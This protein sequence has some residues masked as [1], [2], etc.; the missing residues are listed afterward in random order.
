M[1]VSTVRRLFPLYV[2]VFV[3]FLGYSLMIATFT[4][5][6]LRNEDG[7]LS[8]GSSLTQRSLV[9]GLLLALYP[10]GQFLGS[11]V[12]GALSDGHGR[13]PVLIASLV[14]TTFLYAGI[15]TALAIQS[16]PL[17][18]LA[19]F[20]A[21][22]SEAN[23]VIAQGSITDTV[24]RAE[25]NR[26]FGYVYLSASL[27]Y[28]V[29][30]LGGGKLAD[31]SLVGWFD[32]ATPYW[33]VAILISGVLMAIVAW[34]PETHR[35]SPVQGRYLDAFTNLTR[36]VTDSRLR[37][38]YLVNFTLYLAI[39]GFFRAYPMYL[40]DEFHLGVGKLSEFVAYVAVPIVIA[41]VGLVG[42]LSRRLRPRTMVVF[43]AL[44]MG[45]LMALVVLP[46]SEVSLWFTLAPTALAV[47]VCL[48]SSAAM[49]SLAADDREQG[50][51]MGNNQSMQVGA[52]S[53]SGV[54][55]G[56][57]AANVIKLPLLTFAGAAIVGALALARLG[58][59]FNSPATPVPPSRPLH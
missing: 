56:A 25:R 26:L 54:A 41:N 17:L 36:V 3:G 16:L 20:L 55:S 21:G 7:M 1:S 58:R 59:G 51:A 29:G 32:Y 11:P 18:M 44:A 33:A 57:L 50:R 27:A 43:S 45:V 42:A 24:S 37:P 47:A 30:P 23:I 13:R 46:K 9:L 6:I 34:F 5:M 28:V 49:L 22:V 40:V 4:P 10:L 2:V 19:C 38:L 8:A 12:L 53:L 52:E 31:R 15:A 39:F 14:A 48:P 35:R